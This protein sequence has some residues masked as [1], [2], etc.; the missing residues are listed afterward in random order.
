MIPFQGHIK[1]GGMARGAFAV[2]GN[3]MGQTAET[4]ELMLLSTT[5]RAY[6]KRPRGDFMPNRQT[7]QS[8]PD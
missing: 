1:V 6:R 2:Q 7:I 5:I 8:L 4:A 3:A